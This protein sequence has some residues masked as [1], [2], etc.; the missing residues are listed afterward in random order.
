[1]STLLSSVVYSS[2]GCDFNAG[3]C[4]LSSGTSAIGLRTNARVRISTGML[5]ADMFFLLLP[6]DLPQACLRLC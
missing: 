6:V 5:V 3:Q 4:N 2:H 1:M